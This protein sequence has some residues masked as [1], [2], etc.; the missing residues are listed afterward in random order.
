MLEIIFLVVALIGSIIAA[1]FDLKTTE[2]PDEIP[3]A[4]M[5][6]GIVGHLIKSYINLSFWPFLLSSVVG[7][8]F[9]G[10]GFLMY[11]LG[12]W[13]GGDAKVLSGIGFLVP[14]LPQQIKV[15]LMFPLPI[16]FFFNVFFVGAI[17]M[18]F[19]A[20]IFSVINR[21]ILSAFVEDLK[22]SSKI[23]L[24]F[25][26]TLISF[27]IL[28]ILLFSKYYEFFSLSD[29]ITLVLTI[30]L[31]SSGLFILWKFVKIVE[32]IGFKKRIHVS[33]LKVGDVP[34]EYR[35]WEGITEKELEKIKK[36]G[37]KYIYIKEGVRFAAAFPLALI[38][39][40]LF[41]DGIL[42]LMNFFA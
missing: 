27:F 1:I 40:L 31:V 33:Q 2:I 19:Y 32:E 28:L 35:I 38:F 21:K 24:T 5:A 6:F 36:S 12:Q 41:G 15:S 9:L 18:I 29:A 25:N 23:I 39:T 22:A 37:R 4:M 20:I 3:Y 42:F 7:L 30:L 16:S 34:L 13:G 14:V 17:Y 10:F 26:I 11:F 8:S